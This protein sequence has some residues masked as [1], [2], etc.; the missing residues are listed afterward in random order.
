MTRS[1]SPASRR[2]TGFLAAIALALPPALIS[3]TAG[4]IP[5]PFGATCQSITAVQPRYGNPWIISADMLCDDG[6][7]APFGATLTFTGPP[8]STAATC[9]AGAAVWTGDMELS[10]FGYGFE[11][12]MVNTPTGM[13]FIGSGGTISGVGVLAIDETNFLSECATGGLPQLE[14]AS[15]T[16]TY[17][18]TG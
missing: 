7:N 2:L 17:A 1:H 3:I 12:V 16:W 10:T 6:F 18:V 11:V 4:A 5:T 15:M 9:A 8:P 13:V 14:Q